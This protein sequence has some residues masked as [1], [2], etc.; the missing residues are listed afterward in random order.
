MLF[1]VPVATFV[2]RLICNP[3]FPLA[4]AVLQTTLVDEVTNVLYLL[5]QPLPNMSIYF[6]KLKYVK[7]TS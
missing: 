1:L 3:F 5:Y 6:M 2:G 4:Y 7:N